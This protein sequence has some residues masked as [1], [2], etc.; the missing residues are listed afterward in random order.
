VYACRP[1]AAYAYTLIRN[2]EQGRTSDE[3]CILV[4]AQKKRGVCFGTIFHI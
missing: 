1:Q 2:S 4:T 3:S